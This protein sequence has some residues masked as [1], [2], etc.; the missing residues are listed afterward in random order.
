MDKILPATGSPPTTKAVPPDPPP[1]E[2]IP[3]N[4]PTP[5]VAP[6]NPPLAEAKPANPPAG[7]ATPANPPP[8]DAFE[9]PPLELVPG[10]PPPKPLGDAKPAPGRP[11]PSCL[12]CPKAPRTDPSACCPDPICAGWPNPVWVGA[13]TFIPV[14]KPPE[15]AVE[16]IGWDGC[17]EWGDWKLKD[18]GRNSSPL[19]IVM[20]NA[21]LI[22]LDTALPNGPPNGFDLGA[23]GL[24]VEPIPNPPRLLKLSSAV[25][26]VSEASS[27]I[28][29]SSVTA[30]SRLSF[31]SPAALPEVESGVGNRTRAADGCSGWAFNETLSVGFA[32]LL[33]LGSLPDARLVE[34][35]TV[36]PAILEASSFDLTS[37]LGASDCTGGAC[38]L[39]S[40]SVSKLNLAMGGSVL[41]YSE[42]DAKG[43]FERANV[44]EASKEKEPEGAI[45]EVEVDEEDVETAWLGSALELE[46]VK[47]L[48]SWTEDEEVGTVGVDNEEGGAV[49]ELIIGDEGA[50]TDTGNIGESN[51]FSPGWLLP[52][53]ASSWTFLLR[54]GAAG[55]SN[56]EEDGESCFSS[57]S[58]SEIP[59]DFF[60]ND[61]ACVDNI[62][63]INGF[64]CRLVSDCSIDLASFIGTEP[65]LLVIPLKEFSVAISQ[66]SLVWY[67]PVTGE[68]WDAGRDD[69][70]EI[71]CL[72]NVGDFGPTV[73]DGAGSSFA[74]VNWFVLLEAWFVDVSW[75]PAKYTSKW[76]SNDQLLS[77]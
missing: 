37:P 31:F 3:A 76:K 55:T 32:M 11:V 56:V 68:N 10:K 29:S 12:D 42:L 35:S 27:S 5:E 60:G 66:V 18:A 44:L 16:L 4:P 33:K 30:T 6:A 36:G 50:E 9:N 61:G 64:W 17:E 38:V 20:L 28:S 51:T 58:K 26:L 54:L 71:L 15:N 19:G 65:G 14:P 43:V 52:T 24:G 69:N 13:W 45:G 59:L 47:D 73:C 23:A 2:A 1:A 75:M 40:V 48:L 8:G 72:C 7:D 77:Y 67:F 70:A 41:G 63:G 53:G 62:V 57:D 34:I 39:A 21:E 46:V 49:M 25:L 74:H 22:G